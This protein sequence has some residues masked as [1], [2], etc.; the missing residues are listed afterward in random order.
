MENRP[1]RDLTDDEAF[2]IALADH[3]EYAGPLARGRLP[4]EIVDEHGNRMSPRAHLA[5]H[6]VVERQLAADDPKGVVA[7]ARELE[8][9]GFSPHDV[10]HEI[11]A[12]V[13][14]DLYDI[15][16]RRRAFD[17]AGCLRKLRAAVDAARR[18]ARK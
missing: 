17:A 11:A 18:D 8:S 3:P 2:E 4:G 7:I 6:A 14:E 13:A 12:V 9:L 10:R 16:K 5:M 1:K 15:A